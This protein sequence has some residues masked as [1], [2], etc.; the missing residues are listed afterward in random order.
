VTR[1]ALALCLLPLL[2]A[3]PGLQA[4]GRGARVVTL[5]GTAPLPGPLDW[6]PAGDGRV[7]VDGLGSGPPSVD[8][9]CALLRPGGGGL[10]ALALWEDAL[11]V[12]TGAGPPA[13]RVLGRYRLGVLGAP[14]EPL[15]LS[16]DGSDGVAVRSAAAGTSRLAFFV[17]DD[18]AVTL[19]DRARR[20]TLARLRMSA[21]RVVL[22]GRLLEPVLDQPPGAALAVKTPE[23]PLLAAGQYAA[24]WRGF[25]LLHPV[26]EGLLGS[27]AAVIAVSAALLAVA[28]L[29]ARLLP[30][31]LPAAAGGLA[32]LAVA[33][34]PVIH[35]WYLLWLLPAAALPRTGVLPQA[36]ATLLACGV[37]LH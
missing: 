5:S 16:F 18:G 11:A 15:E 19:F 22:A 33:L 2:P 14:H 8:G 26:L 10:L 31:P 34:L 32:A 28:A 35:P 7:L 9:R 3:E 21:D 36:A 24:R 29:L 17:A 12:A 6:S 37:L 20:A 30:L 4:A 1:A 27:R 25:A 13:H 23:S